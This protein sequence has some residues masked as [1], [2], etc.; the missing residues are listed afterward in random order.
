[1]IDIRDNMRLMLEGI[2]KVKSGQNLVI[3]SDTYA[4]SKSIANII[5][6]IANSIGVQ[7]VL[8]I[9][10]P[11]T[12]AGHEPPP[13]VSIA[14]RVADVILDIEE[15]VN[16]AHTTARK[17]ATE[18]GVKYF[19]MLTDVSEDHFRNP[20]LLEEL[21]A[22]K[23]RTE[24]LAE[25]MTRARVARLTTPYGTDITMSLEGRHAVPIHPLTDAGIT[26]IPDYGEAAI[27]PVEG[28]TEGVVFVD[29]AVRGW[30]YILREPLR[31]EVKEGRVQLGSVS[32]NSAEDAER[33]KKELSLDDNA[34]NCA[35]ELGIGTSHTVGK[36]LRGDFLLDYSM[37]GTA[38]IAYG[39]NNDIGG[40][41]LSRIHTD[42]LM[43]RV[44]IK[45]DE[46]CVI[47]NGEL[48]E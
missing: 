43:T 46:L 29:A 9:M 13:T 10:E 47:E 7:T 21:K 31:F 35:A 27:A 15:K 44:T 4:R 11:R 30:G 33:F 12:H 19:S 14:M 28:T 16:I 22:V 8:T 17:E 1:M 2:M 34:N 24:N 5:A 38:H 6:E 23:R 45:L 40:K 25:I 32:S 3:V 20:I 48:K 26:G 37:I 36:I 41:T 42:V 39:R 18:A